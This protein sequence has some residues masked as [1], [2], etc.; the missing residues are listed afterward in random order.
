MGEGR[1]EMEVGRS[2][3]GRNGLEGVVVWMAAGMEGG[4]E[5]GVWSKVEIRIGVGWI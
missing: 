5:R 4:R 2:G 3:C 1:G